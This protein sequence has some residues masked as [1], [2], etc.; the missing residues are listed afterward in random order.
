MLR[1][2][3][4]M[5]VAVTAHC[6]LPAARCGAQCGVSN[7]GQQ[8]CGV[9][10]ANVSAVN[11]DVANQLAQLTAQAAVAQA[12]V[13]SAPVSLPVAPVAGSA[14]AQAVAPPPA[15]TQVA[16]GGGCASGSCVA[17]AGNSLSLR[18]RLELNR[19]QRNVE[20]AAELAGRAAAGGRL[21]RKAGTRT[22]VAISAAAGA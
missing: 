2:V 1:F 17:S 3:F 7:N 13:N 6:M 11:V 12:P 5:V 22:S 4:C 14:F 20:R 21:A 10:R 15:V 8:G 19:A 9:P 18:Q 16:S